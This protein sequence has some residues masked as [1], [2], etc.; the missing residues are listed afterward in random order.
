MRFMCLE[1]G[2]DLGL[3]PPVHLGHAAEQPQPAHAEGDEERP[4]HERRQGD[5]AQENQR[6]IFHRG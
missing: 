5:H 4:L 3:E 6:Q 2:Q 1:R